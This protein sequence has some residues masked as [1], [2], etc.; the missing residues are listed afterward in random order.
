MRDQTKTENMVEH[1]PRFSDVRSLVETLKPDYPVYC[2]RPSV[3]EQTA[4]QFIDLFP[5]TVM[6]AVKCNPHPLVIDALYQAGITQFDVAS[7]P[8]VAQVVAGYRA[9]AYFMHPVKSRAA[10]KAAYF[11]Y[12]VR[13]FAVDH[14]NELEKIIQETGG[15]NVVIIVRV[16]TPSSDCC[17][18]DLAKKFGAQPEEAANLM[19]KAEKY[20]CQ[21]GVTFHVGSQCTRPE[22][23]G[24]AL[25]IVGEV[26]ESAGVYPVCIDV[27]GGFPVAYPETEVPPLE[28]YML[29]I[30]NG[31]NR[32]NL[33]PQ[34]QV[35]AEP[36]RAL[37]GSGCSI[38]V[39][40]QLRKSDQLY[41]N[42]GIYGAL[43]ELLDSKNRLLA[44]LIRLDGSVADELQEFSIC[45][46]TCDSLDIVPSSFTLPKDVREG[47]W[48]EIDQVGAYSNAL[49]SRFNGFYSEKF[50][51]VDDQ[52]LSSK[53]LLDNA[54]VSTIS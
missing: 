30:K 9:K 48:I 46:A 36:G 47:D 34:V 6:Y 23:Y 31:L 20:G 41:I 10:I 42:D 43:S 53:S 14:D 19:Q 37:V 5:G 52:P 35:L 27:G 21:T 45:G 50:A 39:Q 26:L 40:V 13:H 11:D 51:C 28:D 32:I 25:N 1:F 12:G 2:I 22:S 4:K 8:E 33:D 17:L 29:A 7:Q 18:Y 3:L 44:Q 16:K 38:L 15:D 49:S 54:F 24:A